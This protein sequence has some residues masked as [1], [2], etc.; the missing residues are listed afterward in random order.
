M[1]LVGRETCLQILPS[2]GCLL[3]IAVFTILLLCFCVPPVNGCTAIVVGHQAT[4]DGAGYTSSTSDCLDCDFRLAKVP[5]RE[6]GSNPVSRPVFL[7][8]T[9]YPHVVQEGRADTWRKENLEGSERQINAWSDFASKPIG[10]VPEVEKTYAL[11]ETG[12][13]YGIVNEKM[14]AMSESTC[15]AKFVAKPVNNGGHALFDVGELSRIALERSASARDAIKLMGSMAEQY[16]YYGAEWDTSIKYD[17]AGENLMVSD[18]KEAWVFHILPD[19]TGK[20]AIW[21]AQRVPDDH[22][23]VV[24]NQFIIR[25]VNSS[26][27]RNFM[28]SSNMFAVAEMHGLYDRARDGPLL[29]FTKAFSAVRP[30]SSYSTHRVYR[31]FTLAN[32]D[33]VGKLDPY[34]SVLMDGYPFSVKPKRNLTVHDLFRINR[35]H[36]QDSPWDMT[37]S[38]PAQPFG[39]PDRY[40]TGP[41]GNMSLQ[42]VTAA[43]EFSRAISIGRTSYTA[44]ARSAGAL[45]E[46]VG[47]MVYFAQQQP[48]SSVFIP[49]YVAAEKLPTALT[50]GS[51]L[52]FNQHSMFWAVAAVSNWI[53]KYYLHAIGDLRPV[54]QS[55]EKQFAVDSV[56][57]EALA[58]L[59]NG[60]PEQVAQLLTN[61]TTRATETALHM[62]KELFPRLMARFHDGFTSKLPLT[63]FLVSFF[64]VRRRILH[65]PFKHCLG[66]GSS[67]G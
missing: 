24:A 14:V 13:G 65:S 44:I 42:E 48:D 53:H 22:I 49:V 2:P 39:D 47:A 20:S 57:A 38:T 62:Y 35:D 11:L 46:Q 15:I 10:Y 64:W 6:R 19:D 29:D 28:H 52:R 21:A 7:Y 41:V 12:S 3:N 4:S 26:D 36:Y 33:L 31:V 1:P 40:D 23:T 37:T 59:K 61:F 56:E 63:C 5:L 55:F 25:R 27:T 43:G 50:V 45:P 9:Q 32:P 18:P 58:L 60:K 67:A 54:Q 34:P 17:E 8:R 16:G 30:H 51:L 66:N